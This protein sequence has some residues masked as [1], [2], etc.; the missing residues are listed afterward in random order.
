MNDFP[1]TPRPD[2]QPPED[3]F[4]C[5]NCDTVAAPGARQCLLCGQMLPD[6]PAMPAAEP[7]VSDEAVLD[8]PETD[9]PLSEEPKVEETVAEEAPAAIPAVSEPVADEPETGEPELVEQMD[10][11]ESGADQTAAEEMAADGTAGVVEEAAGLPALD[12]GVDQA[13]AADEAIVASDVLGATPADIEAIDDGVV[14][15]GRPPLVLESVMVER[16][17]RLTLWLTAVFAVIIVVLGLLV[18]RYPASAT[19]SFF[20]TPTPLPPT[21]THTPTLTP[22]PTETSPPTETPTETPIP[23]PTE[24]LQPPRSHSVQSGDTLFGLSL[25]YGVSVE[26]ITELNELVGGGIQVNQQLL[27]PWPTAT[28]PLVPIEVTIGDETIIAD[29]T[30]C[31]R[32]EILGGDTLFGIAAQTGVDLR[33]LLA[34][35][36]LTD[37][38]ILQPGDTICIPQIIRGGVLPPTPGPSATPTNTPPPAGPQLLYPGRESVVE[39]P[40]GPLVLQWAAVKDLTDVEWYMVEVTD[41]T[42]VDSF[43]HRAFTRQNSFR[44]PV[45]WRPQVDENHYFRWRVSIVQVTGEREDGSFI[46]TFG[47]RESA[48]SYFYWLG[49]VPTPTPTPSPTATPTLQP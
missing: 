16:Q 7:A 27:I 34:V 47:G 4:R 29:P 31:Q 30:D 20:P 37:Q 21:L 40:Q 22:I 32:R 41:L 26:S 8:E 25:F 49:A 9:E 14:D 44:V 42:D 11:A 1:D 43:P 13:A 6:R 46:Y 2:P 23:R 28:P 33:A 38:S 10:A 12:Q 5:P 19:V 48:D 18:L 39:P 35:N 45:D 3:D 36:R 24:T 15:D 17:S